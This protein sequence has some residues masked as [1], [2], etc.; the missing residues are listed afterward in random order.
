MTCIYWKEFREIHSMFKKSPKEL[1][2]IPREESI[3]LKVG[4]KIEGRSVTSIKVNHAPCSIYPDYTPTKG[5]NLTNF[6]EY[7]IYFQI[8]LRIELEEGENKNNRD[9]LDEHETYYLLTKG[10]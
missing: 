6:K 4:D 10:D 8:E 2:P 9:V 3:I 7:G 5:V 1:Y